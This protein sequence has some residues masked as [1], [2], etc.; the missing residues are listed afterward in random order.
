MVVLAPSGES[1][2]SIARQMGT[3]HA[4]F[5]SCDELVAAIERFIERWNTTEAHPFRWTYQGL[6]LVR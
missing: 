1:I 2:S 3:R 4:N 5:A 6:P